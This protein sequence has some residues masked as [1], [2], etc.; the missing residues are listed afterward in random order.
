VGIPPERLTPIS[1]I[2]LGLVSGAEP[3]TPYE[4]KQRA[5]ELLDGFW[6]VAHTQLYTEPERLAGAGLLAE[7]REDSGRR[8][9]RYRLTRAGRSALDRWLD[10]PTDD[11]FELRDLALLKV[12]FGA[13]PGALAAAQEDAH[14]ARLGRYE[15]LL[16]ELD[17]S[18]DSGQ[19]LV[20]KA[21]IALERAYIRFWSGQRDKKR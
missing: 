8:R 13:A 12:L 16:A 10:E 19:R 15:A 5:S 2:V 6:S 3:A 21:G 1:Y 17:G 9:K 4:L 18:P 11:L 14:R 7:E 20:V